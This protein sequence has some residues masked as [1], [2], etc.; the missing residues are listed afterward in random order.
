VAYVVW[1]TRR[2]KALAAVGFTVWPTDG[3]QWRPFTCVCAL[4]ASQSVTRPSLRQVVG[5]VVRLDET[6]KSELALIAKFGSGFLVASAVKTGYKTIRGCRSVPAPW[7]MRSTGEDGSRGALAPS[8][9]DG[10]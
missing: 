9:P 2:P 8:L 7:A 10:A 3:S 6:R 5:R 4:F 1:S